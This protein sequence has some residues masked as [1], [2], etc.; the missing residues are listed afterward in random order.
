MKLEKIFKYEDVE[1]KELLYLE[2]EKFGY[3]KI[4]ENPM[5]LYAEGDAPYMLVA[6]LDTVHKESPS[7]I[8]YSKD[9]NY[10]MSPQ[11]IGGDDRCGVYI[12]L[13]LLK[14]L[15]FRPHVVFT[16]E[17]E[18]GGT[19]ASDFVKYVNE[20]EITF[21]NLKYIVEYDRKGK[22]DCVFYDCDNKEFE[23]FVEK[24]GFKT[25]YGS[26]SDISII[27]PALGVAAVNLSSGYY[28]PHTEHEYVSVTDM[29]A[30]IR[31]STQ[32]LNS[33]C[34][35]FKYVKSEYNFGSYRTPYY[36]GSYS[37][38]SCVYATIL[39][40]GVLYFTDVYGVLRTN[41]IDEFAIDKYGK[42]YKQN[43]YF[44]DYSAFNLNDVIPIED[45]SY[46][47]DNVV[48]IELFGKD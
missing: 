25:A 12:I 45:C 46:D 30:T 14:L 47:P 16:M 1:L 13:R 22:D 15:A 28:N 5:F 17:E 27:A 38:K 48:R 42:L 36:Y 7:I 4:H 2:L 31:R 43:R 26:F 44:Q 37:Y 20:K 29:K 40:P 23:A 19:G 11:G 24:F 3:E 34:G 35:V 39:K 10:I 21:P 6:H 18:T 9:G 33:D 8:C 41:R 32:M